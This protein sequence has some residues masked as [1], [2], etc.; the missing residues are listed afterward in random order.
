MEM[1]WI[2]HVR[3]TNRKERTNLSH[4]YRTQLKERGL[5]SARVCSLRIQASSVSCWS[6]APCWRRLGDSHFL[7]R[8]SL[9]W[10][11]SCAWIT[12]FVSP[13]S[14]VPQYVGNRAPYNQSWVSMK[15]ES[16]VMNFLQHVADDPEHTTGCGCATAPWP[17]TLA[18]RWPPVL[19][20]WCR[21]HR[22]GFMSPGLRCPALAHSAFKLEK[23]YASVSPSYFTFEHAGRRNCQRSMKMF[24]LGG[25]RCSSEL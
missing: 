13:D 11:S 22:N 20:E 17:S 8:C 15:D 18:T 4:C 12:I 25:K 3:I 21:T 23:E 6:S 16:T 24:L 14:T 7:T 9:V 5:D 2:F 19:P 1:L 10:F